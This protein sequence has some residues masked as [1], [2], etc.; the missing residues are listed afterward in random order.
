MP[1]LFF[2]LLPFIVGGAIS[3]VI[4]GLLPFFLALTRRRPWL[5]FTALAVC[6]ACGIGLGAILA[7]PLATSFAAAIL[8]TKPR[9]PRH[10]RAK[11]PALADVR[12]AE[13]LT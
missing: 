12:E 8:L 7:F 11:S 6:V 13:S 2:Y 10:K 3:G 9:Q 5:G 1:D 4:C